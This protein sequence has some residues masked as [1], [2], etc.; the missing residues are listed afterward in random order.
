[1]ANKWRPLLAALAAAGL[2]GSAHA[3][4]K[5]ELRFSGFGTLGAVH[6]DD[7]N[8]DFVGT[9]FQP[10]GAGFTRSTSLNPDTK[11]G[12]QLDATFT[13]RFSGVVQMV[14]QHHHDNTYMPKVEWANL[15]FQVTPELSVRGGRI[16][17]PSF[18]YSDTR[19]VGYAQPWVRPPVE[20]YGVLPITSNDGIDVMYR[21]AIGPT[22]NTV[23]AYY[24]RARARLRTGQVESRPSWGI[25]D[26]VQWNDWT[27]RAGYTHNTVDLNL[28][29]LAALTNGA[30]AFT[31]IPGPIGQQAA[32]FVARYSGR[33]VELGA[34]S[35]SASYD[36]GQ[37]FAMSEVVR[38]SGEDIL[39]DSTSWYL[40]GGYRFGAFTPYAVYART[41][42]KVA[43]E[44]GIP[45]PAAAPL[46][47]GINAALRNQFNGTQSTLTAGLRWDFRKNTALKVQVDHI[48]LGDNSAGRFANVQPGFQRGGSVNLFS[49]AL[50]FVF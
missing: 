16:A 25:N 8:A 42:S 40:A 36:P 34:M 19:F 10:N 5:P 33:D 3:Q 27:F 12:V 31:A 26:V 38:L 21:S 41:R 6:S 17:A 32:A 43:T 18:L 48:S 11:L 50:D 35:L 4:W 9:I 29:G 13:E 44:P 47:A 1:M 45:V 22:T 30:R 14:A 2:A 7:R 23:Q 46:N 20:V 28:P 24:G 39:A 49:V 37:W 15:K